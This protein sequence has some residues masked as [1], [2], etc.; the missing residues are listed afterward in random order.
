MKF[1]IVAVIVVGLIIG[2]RMYAASRQRLQGPVPTIPRVPTELLTDGAARTW[3]VFTTPYCASCGPVKEQLALD[4]PSAGIVTVD[5]TREPHLA[6]A[7]SVRS[8][9]TVL[10]A[11][12]DGAVQARLVGAPAVR[13]Y[14][15]A[16][17]A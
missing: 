15:S 4:D 2:R 12:S 8:A 13:D 6:D 1:V 3:V 11:D 9:P 7:F 17:T 10:L 5:A 16:R 14:L